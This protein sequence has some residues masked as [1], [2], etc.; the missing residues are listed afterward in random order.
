MK[1]IRILSI[2]G[3]GIRGII[4]GTILCYLEEQLQ[5]KDNSHL[6]LGD[7]FDFIAGTSTGG[8]LSCIYLIP[9]K[10][11]KAK[12]SAKDAL[13][14]YLDHGNKF[15]NHIYLNGWKGLKD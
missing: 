7:Y 3:G 14:L 2:E 1:K 4:P 15:F 9:T 11:G 12:Y 5:L 6:K 10:D 13:D 8:I